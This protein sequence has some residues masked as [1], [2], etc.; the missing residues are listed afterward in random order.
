MLNIM[1]TSPAPGAGR[2]SNAAELHKRIEAMKLAYSDVSALQRR[3][4][5]F[6]NVPVRASAL[7]RVRPRARISLINPRPR[8]RTSGRRE[9]PTPAAYHLSHGSRPRRK[10]CQLDTERLFSNFGS[11][12][13]VEG[14]GFTLQNR[15]AGFTLDPTHPNVLA[16]GKRP[17][18]TI[19]PALHAAR[20]RAH[21]IRHYGRRNAA[22]R[23]CAVCF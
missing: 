21:R 5:T 11:G 3:S 22:P 2:R 19:I 15:G 8:E 1:E 6:E 4:A 13:T 23:P 16:G 14:M 10:Y 20:Q 9:G 17:Y 18:H 7:E 12:I